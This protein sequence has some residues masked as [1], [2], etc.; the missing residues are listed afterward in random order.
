M[1]KYTFGGGSSFG[2]G[3]S[4]GDTGAGESRA[5]SIMYRDLSDDEKPIYKDAFDQVYDKELDNIDE[6]SI[7]AEDKLFS[8]RNEERERIAAMTEKPD[9]FIGGF[10]LNG[11]VNPNPTLMYKDI[12]NVGDRETYKQAFDEA[13]KAAEENQW[14]NA[15]DAASLAGEH[16]LKVKYGYANPK[17]LSM[18]EYA[19]KQLQAIDEREA[20][21]AQQAQQGPA[22]QGPQNPAYMAAEQERME[23]EQRDRDDAATGAGARVQQLVAQKELEWALAEGSIRDE[24]L[25]QKAEQDLANIRSMN[26][27]GLTL[28]GDGLAGVWQTVDAVRNE[29]TF[30][31]SA[32]NPQN[33]GFTFSAEQTE[34]TED[35]VRATL[36]KIQGRLAEL[37]E[38]DVRERYALQADQQA[39]EDYLNGVTDDAESIRPILAGWKSGNHLTDLGQSPA[40]QIQQYM[41]EHELTPEGMAKAFQEYNMQTM[42]MALGLLTGDGNIDMYH[43]TLDKWGQVGADLANWVNG[44]INAA[45]S[46]G[47]MLV[48]GVG[49][50]AAGAVKNTVNFIK[51]L[52]DL[53]VLWSYG[54]AD[55][56]FGTTLT[57]QENFMAYNRDMVRQPFQSAAEQIGGV[58]KGLWESSGYYREQVMPEIKG[59][60]TGMG[61]D[62]TLAD[63][64]A[65][66]VMDALQEGARMYGNMLPSLIAGWMSGGPMLE[67]AGSTGMV[68]RIVESMKNPSFLSLFMQ[69]TGDAMQT[70]YDK[71]GN[72]VTAADL[73]FA[74]GS[75]AVNA[76]IENY[77]TK[78]GFSNGVQAIA[79]LGRFPKI[80]ELLGGTVSEMSEEL[81]QHFTG[82]GFENLADLYN[83]R[84]LSHAMDTTTKDS[85]FNVA[86]YLDIM[87]TTAV[88]TLGM[89]VLAG[90][91][92]GAAGYFRKAVENAINGTATPQEME[93]VQK[94]VEATVADAAEQVNNTTVTTPTADDQHN[95]FEAA[96]GGENRGNDGTPGTTDQRAQAA[97]TSSA[98]EAAPSPEGKAREEMDR[99]QAE[100]DEQQQL[101]LDTERHEF[102]PADLDAKLAV[103]TEKKNALDRA[104]INYEQAQQAGERAGQAQ[105]TEVT[106][107]Q[108]AQTEPAQEI[109]D[110]QTLQEM[111]Q[112]VTQE[113]IEQQMVQI[114]ALEQAGAD[115]EVIQTMREN[116]E[117]Q[118][119]EL[120]EQEQPEETESSL[121]ENQEPEQ[122]ESQ[123]AE[124]QEEEEPES[125]LVENQ[126][127]E[128][129]ES[130]LVENQEPEEP[131][132]RLV[133][134]EKPEA[135]ESQLVE[136]QKPEEPESQ[137]V[138][139][140]EPEEP[141]SQLVENQKPEKPEDQVSDLVGDEE[142][143]AGE[144]EAAGP[145][146]EISG[147]TSVQPDQETPAE[148]GG[149]EAYAG[150]NVQEEAQAGEGEAAGLQTERDNAGTVSRQYGWNHL[151]NDEQGAK[152][153]VNVRTWRGTSVSESYAGQLQE[154]D[155]FA[156][157]HNLVVIADSTLEGGIANGLYSPTDKQ[158]RLVI[159]I[160]QDATDPLKAVFSHEMMHLISANNPK[161]YGQIE[162]AVFDY[163]GRAG[164]DINNELEKLRTRYKNA[165]KEIKNNAVL[166]EELVAN[167]VFDAIGDQNTIRA[168]AAQDRGLVQRIR[169]W[170]QRVMKEIRE[171][172]NQYTDR[173]PGA[174][175]LQETEGAMER[176][177]AMIEQALDDINKLNESKKTVQALGENG[178]MTRDYQQRVAEAVSREEL[179]GAADLLAWDMLEEMGQ[180]TKPDNRRQLI[181][182]AYTWAATGGTMAEALQ[183]YGFKPWGQNAE[184]NRAFA[185]L[186]KYAQ[187]AMKAGP[188]VFAGIGMN[189]DSRAN[190]DGDQGVRYAIKSFER[191]GKT[192]YYV[193][194]DRKVIK[195]NDPEEWAKQ[196]NRYFDKHIRQGK[197]VTVKTR[198]CSHY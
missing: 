184:M 103:L 181:K 149:T 73:I 162:K 100:F 17:S 122:P 74:M 45:M 71:Y 54:L 57:Q 69:E 109:T 116:V 189:N 137:L 43:P 95:A 175:A 190:A 108:A 97:V 134:N 89:N 23:R 80:G 68:G 36:D 164:V 191:D 161:A 96:A 31:F 41:E 25:R 178:N 61:M 32:E 128:E 67:G 64:V 81:K 22:N 166:R 155:A 126:G 50:G 132:G 38:A 59:L 133:E 72:G 182:A 82:Y 27:Q 37:G 151:Q 119:Q 26:E 105:Q 78:F 34:V 121:V 51:G 160:A 114:E 83:G 183:E 146:E 77:E 1:S 4:F 144:G 167:S 154:A 11:P 21:Q 185:M 33:D 5:P 192:F 20:Y 125:K 158:G 40:G 65:S 42:Q 129:P 53:G 8:W 66:K 157:R 118:R 176:L 86:D 111:E 58:E 168:L 79:N 150:E 35:A 174:K 143:E 62:D 70:A 152:A 63:G 104:R 136:N 135:P 30:T 195:G 145:A 10:N 102:D 85:L 28:S 159:H 76:I 14:F 44:R 110:V 18:S 140:Q 93:A 153:G 55:M 52:A 75:G 156:K 130:K 187:D 29:P 141:E 24:G 170:V 142:P 13:Y 172:M 107:E 91:G 2:G 12:E 90:A 123:L 115:P 147:E 84:E 56:M 6:A 101:V 120:V 92:S 48:E 131:E 39:L 148:E 99:A 49:A 179:N 163:L 15:T 124:N 138:E 94:V 165:G 87:A 46:G 169:D 16:A 197:D 196:L 194:S 117:Q 47:E 106:E 186:G 171:M 113:S 60:L 177:Q 188:E 173:T 7:A 19:A 127:P 3:G 88:S 9:K 112:P 198:V 193:E 180:A 139:N 98:A